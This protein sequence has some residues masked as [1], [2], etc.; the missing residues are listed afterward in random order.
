MYKF[1]KHMT[2]NDIIMT[3]SPITMKDNGKGADLVGTKQNK[4]CSN[5]LR[6]AIQKC[7]FIEF[8]PL[9]QKLWAFMLNLPKS[10]TKYGHVT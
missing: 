7:N 6:R 4:Y 2:R 8:K 5:V 1:E 3:S 9:C 10:F